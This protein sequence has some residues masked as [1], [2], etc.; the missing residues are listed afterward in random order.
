MT[1][2]DSAELDDDLSP[3]HPSRDVLLLSDD[4][5]G[6]MYSPPAHIAARLQ[7]HGNRRRSSAASSR[8]NSLSSSHSHPSIRSAFHTHQVAQHLRR[9][10]I[11]ETRRQKLADRAA[12]VEQV[13]MRAALA[14][15][16]PR[17]SNTEERSRA[18]EQAREK[19][20]AKVAAQ[21]AEE[22]NRAKKIAE[23]MKERKAAEERRIRV[24][25]EEKHAEAERR[26]QEYKRS[27]RKS[28]TASLPST[29]P[30]GKASSDHGKRAWSEDAAAQ[31]IQ[32]LWRRRRRAQATKRFLELELNMD[33]IRSLSFMEASSFLADPG[34]IESTGRLMGGVGLDGD[35]P[36]DK[37]FIR[38][39][40]S[41]FMILGHPMDVFN[42][43]GQQEQDLIEKAKE[44]LISFEALL[45][46]LS[47]LSMPID[48]EEL[49]TL[50]QAHAS[51]LSVFD[52]WKTK[53]ATVLIETM[54]DQFVALDSIWQTVK[55]DTRGE[56]AHD[57]REGIR[58]QQVI[59][60]SK[61]KKLAGP[62]KANTLIKRA[63]RESRRAR[64]RT[65]PTGDVRP[66]PIA[67]PEA[68]SSG[69]SSA[70]AA[71]E[72]NHH[73]SATAGLE[74][75]ELSR[76]FSLVPPNRVLVHELQLD[77]TF[78]LEVSP[79][80]DVRNALNQ[81]I[82]N[83]M[84]RAVHEG[85]GA[86]WTLAVADNMRKRLLKLVQP[87]NAMYRLLDEVL[88]LVHIRRQCDQ[89][90]FSYETFFGFMAEILPKLCAPIRDDEVQALA[91][92]L[93]SP[94]A[95]ADAMIE[96][97]FG[98]L[99]MIDLMSLDYTNY[100]IQ[101]AAPTLIHE[102]PGYEQRVFAQALD[103]GTITLQRTKRWWRHA[104]VSAMTEPPLH[105]TASNAGFQRIY[106]RGLVDLCV[107]VGPL[108]AEDVPETLELDQGRCR[109]IRRDAL[110]MT[111]VG[112][113]LLTAKNLLK[114]DVR[115]QWKPEAKR[116]LDALKDG[117]DD[118]DGNLGHR[119][120]A[121]VSTTHGMPQ[122]SRE[123]LAG[124]IQ[125]VLGECAQGRLADPVLKLLFQRLKLHIF[126][127]LAA[128]SSVERVRVASTVSEG[129]ASIGLSEFIGQ[130]G[131]ISEEL[132]RIG[133]VDQRSHGQWYRQ[134]AE[135]LERIGASE[136]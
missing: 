67:G 60:L 132:T 81:E 80:S 100:M 117:F 27:P 17:V 61:I 73:D 86:G 115:S 125:R 109:R 126:N 36:M 129:L 55:D 16:V 59:L 33:H 71:H 78:R 46:Q 119:V 57:Y 32:R 64:A 51:Y 52:A 31:K 92:V 112:A 38:R 103:A 65:R 53:D 122:T 107:S 116:V 7:H 43:H 133:G 4:E 77:R 8:R 74:T 89:G 48:A 70:T 23:E 94:S 90:V 101:Q 3:L 69:P 40:L 22:V 83:S 85:D 12:H 95:G 2:H 136:A 25:M 19:Y 131:D 87:G 10:S 26:R 124:A 9:A 135:E 104:S 93:Q 79:H 37:A 110:Q 44:L 5:N 39:F 28:R 1:G 120:L 45:P 118:A 102:A 50:S 113:I 18:A 108:R 54:V 134:I 106:A 105:E 75:G 15:A 123:Q 68:G 97:L 58:D 56:V 34:V 121:I 41:A 72:L 91:S 84:R 130:V 29:S 11:I 96:K 30:R 14:R 111:A 13:R 21:C 82:C 42:K 49:Q 127:R 6:I 66:R 62:D 24:E 20:L 88:D 76:I 35:G 47:T 63:I 114:R 98:L 128:T 99:H